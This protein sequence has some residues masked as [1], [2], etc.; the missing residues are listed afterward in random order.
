MIKLKLHHKNKHIKSHFLLI[1]KNQ[2]YSKSQV[3]EYATLRI[4]FSRSK[5][6]NK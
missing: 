1:I 2:D 5:A 6:K 3:E 4:Y